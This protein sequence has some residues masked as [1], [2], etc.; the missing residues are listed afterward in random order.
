MKKLNN[1]FEEIFTDLGGDSILDLNDRVEPLEG[2]LWECDV[3]G[4]YLKCSPEVEDVL[5]YTVQEMIGK[6]F[7]EFALPAKSTRKIS[8][9]LKMGNLPAEISVDFLKQ[10]G[11]KVPVSLFIYDAITTEE[12]NTGLRGFAQ[13]LVNIDKVRNVNSMQKTQQSGIK[14]DATTQFEGESGKGQ[15]L[16]KELEVEETEIHLEVRGKD[17]DNEEVHSQDI[18]EEGELKEE[19]KIQV[20][21]KLILESLEKTRR[22]SSVIKGSPLSRIISVENEEFRVDRSR[23]PLINES[24][25][26]KVVHTYPKILVR[27][28]EHKLEWGIKFDFTNE[29]KAFLSRYRL[30]PPGLQGFLR[31]RTAPKSILKCDYDW[32]SVLIL[33][34]QGKQTQ[35]WINFSHEGKRSGGWDIEDVVRDV[36]LV[37]NEIERAVSQPMKVREILIRGENYLLE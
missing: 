27:E 12:K 5:G 19:S 36:T 15:L 29:E 3:A 13:V 21:S 30:R 33:D 8:N 26:G 4:D 24:I 37:L 35:I 32:V 20:V 34:Q 6:P 10:D 31:R 2:W 17:G 14:D 22:N 16:E 25:A 11:E 1:L 9:V 18:Q 28:T 23:E 7:S